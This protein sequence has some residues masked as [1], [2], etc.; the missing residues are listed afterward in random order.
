M[1]FQFDN[2]QSVGS[3]KSLDRRKV[4][5]LVKFFSIEFVASGF[6]VTFVGGMPLWP[7]G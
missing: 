3:V 6:Q 7:N 5:I 4:F 2:S 1:T